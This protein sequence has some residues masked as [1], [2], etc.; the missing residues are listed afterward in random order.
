MGCAEE[1][2]TGADL[3]D[4]V[5]AEGILVDHDRIQECGDHLQQLGVEDH[6][7]KSRVEAAFHPTG[8]MH[9]QVDPAHHGAP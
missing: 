1:V 6:L 2:P 8:P 3:P 7:L 5:K 9:Q 4:R